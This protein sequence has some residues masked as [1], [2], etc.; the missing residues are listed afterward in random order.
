MSP[1]CQ[2]FWGVI[3][4]PGNA[5]K[6]PK[7][8]KKPHQNAFKMPQKYS[9]ILILIENRE[10][11]SLVWSERGRNAEIWVHFFDE[12]GIKT[13]G[14][15]CAGQGWKKNKKKKVKKLSFGLL[16]EQKFSE[17]WGVWSLGPL[18]NFLFSPIFGTLLGLIFG[19][20]PS[21]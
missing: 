13:G 4:C 8:E 3:S 20:G 12:K 18:K 15:G 6:Y 2:H 17:N 19:G 21:P 10:F 9:E 5:S 7:K 1:P 16:G 14:L 11:Q